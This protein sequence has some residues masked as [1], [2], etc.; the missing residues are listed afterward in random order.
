MRN[1][2]FFIAVLFSIPS[3]TQSLSPST[4]VSPLESVD[5]LE[6]NKLD[7]AYLDAYY[8]S[9]RVNKPL[10][11][12]EARDVNI[13]PLK[14]GTWE[15][16]RSGH[17]VWRQ[18]VKSP[19]AYS[20]NLAFDN[21]ELPSSASLFIYNN[22]KSEVFGPFTKKDNDAHRQLWT[23]MVSGDEIIIEVHVL[24]AQRKQVDF[25][26]IRVNHD[27]ANIQSRLISGSCNLDVICGASDGWGIVDNYRDII[28]SVGAYTLNGI[29]QCSG[30]LINN[31]AQDCRPFFLTA[32]H[33][34]ISNNNSSSVVVF[35]N[36]ENSTCRQPNSTASGQNGDGSRAS[37]NSGAILR[38]ENFESDFALIEFDDPIDPTLDL[39]FAG[40]SRES[41][42]PDTTICIHHPNVEEKRIS[43]EF[44]RLSYEINNQDTAYLRVN[45]WDIGTTE[46]GSSGSPLFNTRKQIVG[47]LFGG[48]AACG[49]DES[50][51]YGWVR[52]SW[53]GRGNALTR[54]K[55]WLD[56]I[57]SN[58]LSLDGRSCSFNLEASETFV[59]LCAK[60][61]NSLTIQLTPAEVFD[62]NLTYSIVANEDMIDASFSFD[63]GLVTQVNELTLNNLDALDEGQSEI[64]VSVTDGTNT[65][66]VVII[67]NISQDTPSLPNLES[68]ADGEEGVASEAELSIRRTTNTNN[69]FQ[70]STDPL[71][72]QVI[73]ES[74]TM[75]RNVVASQLQSETE[76]FWRVRSANICGESDWS[77]TYSFT[78]TAIYCTVLESR[79]GPVEIPESQATVTSTISVVY[80]L[81]ASSVRI[82]NMEGTHSYLNDLVVNLEFNGNNAELFSNICDDQDDFNLGFDDNSPIDDII[83]PPT[84][85]N[86]YQPATPLENL[87]GDISGGN[88][89]LR[90]EDTAFL[91]GGQLNSWTLELCFDRT[92]A[93]TIIPS[94][95]NINY[96]D[97]ESVEV[98]FYYSNMDTNNDVN[99]AVYDRDNNLVNS[100]FNI[101]ATSLP[102]TNISIDTES[103]DDQVTDVRVELLDAQTGTVLS[104]TPLRLISDQGGN[105][106]QVDF[107]QSGVTYDIDEVSNITWNQDAGATYTVELSSD[108]SFNTILFSQANLQLSQVDI[109]ALGLTNGDY[110]VR[111]LTTFDCGVVNSNV[112]QF[113]IDDGT[114]TEDFERDIFKIYPNPSNGL[115]YLESGLQLDDLNIHIYDAIG[116]KQ[117]VQRYNIQAGLEVIDISELS[118]GVYYISVD[119]GQKSWLNK[120]IKI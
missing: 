5:L 56:P 31:T 24:P 6:L 21:F 86:L 37:F 62:P 40:W 22:D 87:S 38:A 75:G 70:I 47:Q 94:R 116:R 11:F 81:I 118:N 64:E 96:C 120:L 39:F 102:T 27:F 59:S 35:W 13:S 73:F 115:Y 54:L 114:F 33:C 89:E 29:D 83:C 49:N 45:D 77:E 119:N 55:D 63:Q 36:Y 85:G 71:F 10:R 34:D 111:V 52:H 78:T 67:L 20:I 95:N 25:K 58:A 68:P 110:Y 61:E 80:P 97:N 103:F 117:K 60:D 15:T 100:S 23:P 42:L 105:A 53:E 65:G 90:I 44:D 28:K 12:A 91:D 26:L 4:E 7:N 57:G 30:V 79:D 104:V 66:S 84:D 112:V 3:F 88:W 46:G 69:T 82:L 101:L 107:P 2:L 17:E 98:N 106:A 74:T 16:V 18:R 41:A 109:S 108:A 32:E 50:D 1:V 8:K 92:A 48:F 113:T 99:F 93:S 43:F 19:G 14:Q 76:Y 72:N 9:P 51:T